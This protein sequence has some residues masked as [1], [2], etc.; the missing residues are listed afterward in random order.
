MT[1]CGGTGI[2][3]IGGGGGEFQI[4]SS[5]HGQATADLEG[6]FPLDSATEPT[7]LDS[8]GNSA[9]CSLGWLD[10]I[11]LLTDLYSALS[12]IYSRALPTQ[13]R[14]KKNSLE[15][16]CSRILSYQWVNMS[17]QLRCP[18]SEEKGA[19]V[20]SD[21]GV[22]NMSQR[23]DLCNLK[24]EIW[25]YTTESDDCHTKLDCFNAWKNYTVVCA[26]FSLRDQCLKT[27]PC[28]SRMIRWPWA[29]DRV[30]TSKSV[31]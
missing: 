12:G 15:I 23:S 28:L 31:G 27:V 4:S 25:S 18:E 14:A 8:G 19:W 22:G 30:P 11:H 29:Q 2:P 13:L 7:R 10:S 17:L 24:F 26:C 20:K 3:Y 5:R 21:N 16:A 6:N 9:D 1:F